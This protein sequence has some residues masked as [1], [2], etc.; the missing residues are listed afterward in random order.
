[1]TTDKACI[2]CGSTTKQ[3]AYV[4]RC[5]TCYRH[6]DDPDYLPRD[7]DRASEKSICIECKHPDRISYCKK[8]CK[9][10]Y[11]KKRRATLRPDRRAYGRLNPAITNCVSCKLRDPIYS[12]GLCNVCYKRD[13]NREIAAGR[14]NDVSKCKACGKRC[15]NSYEFCSRCRKQHRRD[16]D[17]DDMATSRED[18]CAY[19]K[20][21]NSIKSRGYCNRHYM[22]LRRTNP[23]SIGLEAKTCREIDCE[24]PATSTARCREHELETRRYRDGKLRSNRATPKPPLTTS[25]ESLWDFVKEELGIK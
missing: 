24:E 9:P 23:A 14:V 19:D 13:R 10:C 7:Y 1:M 18:T 6:R 11:Y 25:A 8:M 12:S 15:H 2:N 21:D 3:I 22:W 20:C 5:H 16:M 4:G 17:G